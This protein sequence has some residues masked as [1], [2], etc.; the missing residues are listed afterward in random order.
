[1][2]LKD[3]LPKK[4]SKK[5][6]F[7]A[8]VLEPGWVQAGVWEVGDGSAK[9]IATSTPAPWETDEELISAADTALSSAIQTLPEEGGEP[10]KTVFGVPPSW[11][12]GGQ[13]KE[14]YLARIKSICSDLSL[15][16]SGFVV[17]P[18]AIAHLTKSEEGS[19]LNAIVIG[20]GKDTL[21][22]AVFRLG[23]LSGTTNVARSVSVTDDV[24]EG[25]SR[26]SDGEPLPS[27]F[28]LYDGKDGELEE[29]RQS[30]ITA[31]WDQGEKVKFLHTPKAEVF[32]P[33]RKVLATALAGASEIANISTLETKD[34]E[35][36][37]VKE[38]DG[39]K[40]ELSDVK[41][42]APESLGFSIGKDVATPAHPALVVPT[43]GIAQKIKTFFGSFLG[44][45]K[46]V[47]SRVRV[48]NISGL[49]AGRTPLF[50]LGFL[51]ALLILGF[52]FWWFYPKA[53]VTI[54][55]SAK[56]IE[57]KLD[58]SLDPKIE[59]PDLS[60]N[61][62]PVSV[63]K[64]EVSGDKT[65]GTSGTK[66]VGDRAK[67]VVKIQNG[68]SVNIN[69]P[70]GTALVSTNTLT[71][72]LDKT[73]TVT[74][75]LSPTEPG[76]ATADVTAGDIGATYNLANGEDFKVGNYPKAEVNAVATIDFSGGSSRE[77][78][79]VDPKDQ[80]SLLG[81]LQDELLE[82]AKSEISSEL[83]EDK[84]LI[85][86]SLSPKIVLKDFSNKVGDEAANLKLDLSLEVSAYVVAKKDLSDF[87]QGVFKDKAPGGFVL[88]ENQIDYSFKPKEDEANRDFEITITANFLPEA[89]PDEIARKIAGKL[90]SLAQSYLTSIPGF[91]RAEVTIK[92]KFPGRLGT[93]PHVAKNITIEVEAER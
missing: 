84:Y 89:K 87:S 52:A 23:N 92:P 6:L 45:G 13:I 20:V 88:R 1:M 67:G 30:L 81:E 27:R 32:S 2:N 4:E 3:F 91:A 50:G 14:E 86:G 71:Y 40:E 17:L 34:K 25:L 18:E 41:E 42:V 65:K 68:T 64:K 16:P 75:A 58:I 24:V 61:T 33:E 82:K 10:S 66:T 69:L 35:A 85:A 70:A 83:P 36:D 78:S 77:I 39:S 51:L 73:T 59:S 31:S 55:V 56:R 7:W 8:L 28:I 72:T 22:I 49:G 46:K 74:A 9:I 5:D 11:V 54:F 29:V 15:E 48:P 60:K 53:E 63:T 38:P 93:L 12:S 47:A 90:P 37:K 44:F 21:E 26:F 43:I 76:T 79:A 57:E 19:P 80:E 62:L